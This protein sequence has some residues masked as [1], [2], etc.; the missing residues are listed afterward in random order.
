[1][2]IVI[3]SEQELENEAILLNQLFSKGLEVLHLRKPS[4]NIEQ[5]RVLLKDI[6]AKFYNRIMIHENHELCTEFNLRGIHLQE[7][8]RID[9]GDNL[10][11]YTDSYKKKGFKVS[12]SFH[13]PKVLNRCEIDFEYHLLSPVFSSISKIGYEGKGFDV[14]HISKTVIG[15][16]GVNAAT[17]PEVLKLGYEGIGVLGGVWNSE[18]IVES[19]KEIKRRYEEETT[20]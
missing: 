3:T 11:N 6:N 14:N 9:L 1:M 7:Q 15:M 4:F 18:N 19:F 2:L 16:G 20:K 10:K 5:Y 12:S 17:I 13:D 8:P